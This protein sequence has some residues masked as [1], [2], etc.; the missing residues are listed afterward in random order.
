[1]SSESLIIVLGIVLIVEGMPWFLSPLRMKRMLSEL[2]L[3]N[4]RA[5]RCAGLA[6]MLFGLLLVY[7]AKAN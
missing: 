4:D 6:L 3:V 2:F 7:L 5:L 1:M